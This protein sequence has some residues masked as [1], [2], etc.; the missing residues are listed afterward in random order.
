M[1]PTRRACDFHCLRVN[2]QVN[3]WWNL[4]NVLNKEDCGFR[5]EGKAV[6]P[7]I[8]DMLIAPLSLLQS[9]K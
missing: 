7:I 5:I 2:F 8:T 1:A 9:K 6:L 3:T 4:K